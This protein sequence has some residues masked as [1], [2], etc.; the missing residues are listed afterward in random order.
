MKIQCLVCNESPIVEVSEPTYEGEIIQCPE[1]WFNLLECQRE[2]PH[3]KR[4][5]L[6]WFT[7]F[8]YW[9]DEHGNEDP[10]YPTTRFLP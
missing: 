7:R 2:Y 6:V 10:N 5:K 1:C 9:R 4:D 3:Q 8:K